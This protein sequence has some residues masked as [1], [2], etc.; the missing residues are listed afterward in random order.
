MDYMLMVED[1]NL[2]P[3]FAEERLKPVKFCHLLL[4]QKS[5]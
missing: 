1:G 4:L 5:N 3:I 2:E